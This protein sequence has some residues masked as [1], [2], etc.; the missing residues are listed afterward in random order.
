[1]IAQLLTGFLLLVALI[2]CA[3][4]I[5]RSLER[6]METRLEQ[7]SQK[8]M[9][10]SFESILKLTSNSLEEKTKHIRDTLDDKQKLFESLVSEVKTQVKDYQQEIKSIAKDHSQLGTLLT[11]QKEAVG[12]LALSADKLNRVLHTNNLRGQWG[13][14]IAEDILRGSGLLEGTH[15]QKNKQQDTSASR[16][17]YTFFLPDGH[18]LNLD[19]KF[20]VSNLARAQEA[21]DPA[22]QKRY[23]KDFETD[24]KRRIDEVAKKDYI[25]PDENTVDFAVL[26]VPS[27]SVYSSIHTL[28]PGVFEIAEDRKVV[29]AAPFSLIAI[30]K[31][32]HQAFR[33]FYFERRIREIVVSIQKLGDDLT[34]F[35][36]TFSEFGTLI[37]KLQAMYD[38]ISGAQFQKINS[39]IQ[40]IE[41]YQQGTDAESRPTLSSHSESSART[42]GAGERLLL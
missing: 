19:V 23:L 15:Y 10:D 38:K 17:D 32:I 41:Q 25:N 11:E 42:A 28:M 24:V 36:E 22:E 6:F 9:N 33:N 5:K 40:K 21:E 7:V 27:E 14:R 4:W 37:Q 8:A 13:E 1:M 2:G 35:Q 20:P 3:I 16:P 12:H 30:L 34:R 31:V 26:F 18:K 29:I 39:K